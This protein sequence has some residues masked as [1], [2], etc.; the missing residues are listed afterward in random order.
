MLSKIMYPRNILSQAL[1]T[2]CL[3]GIS[4]WAFAQDELPTL[5]ARYISVDVIDPVRDAGYVVGDILNRE[6]TITIKKPYE[7]VSESLPIIGYEHRYRGKKSGIELVN[8]N[9]TS[10]ADS[11]SATYHLALSYQVFKTDRVA[12]PAALR[13]EALKIR[14]TSNKEVFQ[15]KLPDFSFRISPLS[16]IGQIKLDQEMYPYTAPLTLDDSKVIANIKTLAVVLAIALLGLLYI[17]GSHAWLP[18]MGAPFAKAYRDIKKMSDSPE[19]IE[20]AVT[21]MHTSLNKTAGTTLFS[22]NLAAFIAAQPA[23]LPVKK[24]LEQFFGLSHQVFFQ[25]ASQSLTTED[26][27]K[28]LLQFCRRLRDCERGLTP[29]ALQSESLQGDSRQG[30]QA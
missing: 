11:K 5:D 3:I 9:S 8:I 7:L 25:D 14:N 1:V 6:V 27:K 10:T 17:F 12:K 21:S 28:W 13:A 18:K 4:Q 22:N 26:P 24:E 15:Y 30:S 29:D 16:L 20:Q 2:L 19:G 23:F